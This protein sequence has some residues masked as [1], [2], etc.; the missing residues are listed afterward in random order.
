MFSLLSSSSSKHW[1]LDWNSIQVPSKA[2]AKLMDRI[3]PRSRRLLTG[4][5]NPG[6]LYSLWKIL[7]WKLLNYISGVFLVYYIRAYAKTS[8]N[9]N[10]AIMSQENVIYNLRRISVW[11][12]FKCRKWLD[13][14]IAVEQTIF[15]F[16]IRSRKM[17]EL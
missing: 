6:P 16:Q 17:K 12:L 1:I 9:T 2:V 13:A 14:F 10:K 7:G 11:K 3:S 15:K 8:T 4:D 5:C